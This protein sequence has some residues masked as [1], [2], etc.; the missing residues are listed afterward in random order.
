MNLE[1]QILRLVHARYMEKGLPKPH[2][3]RTLEELTGSPL[4]RVGQ[5]ARHLAQ[6]N[7]IVLRTEVTAHKVKASEW[8]TSEIKVTPGERLRERLAVLEEREHDNVQA[9]AR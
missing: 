1:L 9:D 3:L 4:V 8:F 6:Q 2:T 7:R 5:L